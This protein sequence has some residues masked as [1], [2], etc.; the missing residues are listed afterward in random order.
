MFTKLQY[1]RGQNRPDQA[2]KIYPFSID[3]IFM[4]IF[5]WKQWT[6]PRF[7]SVNELI[8]FYRTI[9]I[10]TPMVSCQ[11]STASVYH[12]YV[13]PCALN[14]YIDVFSV[15]CSLLMQSKTRTMAWWINSRILNNRFIGSGYRFSKNCLHFDKLILVLNGLAIGAV[16]EHCFFICCHSNTPK[17][18]HVLL[19]PNT[20][21]L[22]SIVINHQFWNF[23]F[24]TIPSLTTFQWLCA[25]NAYDTMN[26]NSLVETKRKVNISNFYI[27]FNM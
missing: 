13:Y 27:R 19:N 16:P 26:N 21:I 14:G 23:V 7:E 3:W 11:L 8:I 10:L 6:F 18:V 20:K 22:D 1:R 12:V 9:F 5:P 25:L 24:I 2:N 15:Q 17:N 4:K